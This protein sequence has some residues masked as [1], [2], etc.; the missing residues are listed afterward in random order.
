[1]SQNANEPAA[2][3]EVVRRNV[4]RMHGPRG[5]NQQFLGKRIGLVQ[6]ASS[7]VECCPSV[8]ASFRLPEAFG[9]E[10]ERIV[11]VLLG[12]TS[13]RGDPP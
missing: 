6:W 10:P 4:R 8:Q 3:C 13:G 9:A 11:E 12:M 1:M 7:G 5:W 2:G